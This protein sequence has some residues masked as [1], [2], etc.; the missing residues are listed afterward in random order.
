MAGS[1]VIVRDGE[2]RASARREPSIVIEGGHRLS[3]TVPISGSKNAALAL[4]AGALLPAEG[5]TVL[6]NLPRIT[7]IADLV[8]ILDCIGV[9]TRFED[10]GRTVRID[11]TKLRTY[12]PPSDLVSRMRGSLQLLGPVLARIGRVRLAQPGGCNIGARAIDLHEKGLRALGAAIEVGEG[13]IFAEAPSGGL[14]G[15]AVYL[16]KPSVGATMNLMMA[17][18]LADGETIIENAAQEPDVE[19][20]A[21]LIVAMGGSVSG[22]GTGL[23]RVHGVPRLHGADFV[24]SAD[25]I[26][27]GTYAMAAA[28]TG[29]DLFLEGAQAAH[30]RPILMKLAELGLRI[31]ESPR[32]V[33][34]SHP[35]PGERLAAVDLIAMPHPGFPTDLQQPWSS[36]VAALADGTC[37][38]VDKVYEGRFRHLGE[39]ARMGAK[40]KV[41]GQTAVITGVGA[42]GGAD[43]E[44]SDL[45]AGAGLV[46]AGLAA[47]GRTRV[48]GIRHIDRGYENLVAKLA[49][50]GASIW[51]EDAAGNPVREE[52]QWVSG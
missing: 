26:E 38:V 27:G 25:R 19:D 33:R 40:V 24:V 30:L 51:R 9:R 11:A 39:L 47:R 4:I 16:D 37:T 43:V 12:E 52:L 41:E 36:L 6:R 31:E 17:A 3:G 42:L 44:A 46:L 15:A 13:S 32:G 49:A 18:A 10:D 2:R 14:R 20:L 8:A 34:V 23:V 1:D 45:R 35:A 7:D 50:V 5:E 48:Y 22:Q 29:G 28:I 21:N